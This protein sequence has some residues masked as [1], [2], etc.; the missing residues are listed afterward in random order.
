MNHVPPI[1]NVAAMLPATSS[2]P[3]V[4][5]LKNLSS[6]SL[7]KG[8]LPWDFKP[9][10]PG[11][12]EEARK[13][14]KFRDV[15]INTPATVHYVY[16]FNEGVNPNL[17]IS[18]DRNDGGGNPPHASHGLVFDYDSAQSEEKVLAYAKELPYPPN[19][20][21]R[22]LSGN[23]RFICLVEVPLI[24]PSYDFAKH[25]FKTFA[26]F[27]FDPSRGCPGFDKKAFE[28][29]ERLWTNGCDWR[30]LHDEKIPADVVQG[31]IVKA[32]ANYSFSP[33]EFGAA[34]PLDAIKPELA[35]R[36][37]RFTSWPGDF[38]LNS[39][40]PTFWMDESTSPKSAI[41]R[42]TGIQT[43]AAHA[44][45]GFYSW[46]DLLGIDFV[47]EYEAAS[48]G[49]AVDGI[50]HDGRQY[51]QRLPDSSWK[52]F[53]KD[54]IQEHLHVERGVSY[55][56]DNSGVS[57]MKRALVFIRKF[58]SVEATGPYI[59]RPSGV[60][61]R[62]GKKY[63]NTSNVRVMAPAEGKTIYGPEGQFAWVS[64]YFDLFSDTDREFIHS[65]IRHC[66]ENALKLEPTPGQVMYLAGPP[67]VGKTLFSR[68]VL[69]RILGGM[70][71]IGAY[72]AGTD[73][74]NAEQF[75]APLWVCDDGTTT[76][77]P[78]KMRRTSEVVKAV[79]A[80]QTFRSNGKYLKAFLN[81]WVGR[82]I[83]TLN[84]DEE[85][86]RGLPDTGNSIL[87]KIILI[88]TKKEAPHDYPSQA[89]ITRILEREL[90]WY[91]CWL[92]QTSMP[93]HLRGKS[94][95]GLKQHHD[96][97]LLAACRQS[98]PLAAFVEILEDWKAYYFNQQ[99]KEAMVWE[100]TAFQ[101]Q[102]SILLDSATHSA[103]RPYTVN[104]IN[105]HLSN[106]CQKR[107]DLESIS[108]REIRLWRIHR[109]KPQ[110]SN[111]E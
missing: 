95:F 27:A 38:V 81:E 41:V 91:C 32:S 68:G 83:I 42:E 36:Y 62:F 47:R 77:D 64:K 8:M 94:R 67:G 92:L 43:F 60:I 109:N 63:L 56:I 74:F 106:L 34:I 57:Q 105:G 85:S 26:E 108:G 78:R 107:S 97:E 52:A 22:T 61:E 111:A 12:P 71:E 25:F 2:N 30:K 40:G 89:E 103:M 88:Q 73:S 45:K 69:S 82:M 13:N 9:G 31:W 17:R 102:K 104:A 33:R 49:R 50:Y 35:K 37:P 19:W 75:D 4:Y 15:W 65:W 59:Y 70:A 16:S 90:P 96:A 48:I 79:A 29:P 58:Q 5:Y 72:L 98:S 3:H 11:I 24:F 101:L 46:A 80:N 7:S 10:E 44:A 14:K 28:A 86:L 1:E 110:H 23:W 87:D 66:Y 54:D 99:E 20:I 21:E 6:L 84:D 18:K 93:E 55:K 53:N 100:G 39:Q 51:W 76:T